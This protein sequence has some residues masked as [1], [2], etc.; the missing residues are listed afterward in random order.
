M[1]KKRILL[2]GF[3]LLLQPFC[4]RS[5]QFGSS[6]NLF[7]PSTA[8]KF[9]DIGYELANKPSVSP[10]E[11]AAKA[12]QALIFMTAVTR[13]DSHSHYVLADMIR[14]ASQIESPLLLG[15]PYSR[16]ALIRD[17]ND[18]NAKPAPPRDNSELIM[19]ALKAYVNR[20]ADLE[21]AEQAIQYLLSHKDTREQKEKLLAELLTAF[22]NKND[23]LE[24]ELASTLGLLTAEK[25][26][27]AKA[28]ILF[29]GAYQK[30]RYNRTAFTKLLEIEP[31]QIPAVM[32]LEHLRYMLGENPLDIQAALAFADYSQ[33]LQLFEIACD[34]YEY[35]ASLFEYLYPQ[36]TLPEYIYLGLAMS[37]YNTERNPLKAVQVAERLSREG[38][39]DLLLETIA[40]RA[41]VKTG[42][43]DK[44]KSL[45]NAAEKAALAQIQKT[46]ADRDFLTAQLA[47]FYCFAS[48]QAD[49]AI[50]WANKAYAQ[51]PNNSTAA[52]LLA[53]AFVM[54]DNLEWAKTFVES[55]NPNPILNL[56]KARIDLSQDK[57]ENAIATLKAIIDSSPASIEANEARDILKSIG[58]TYIPAI[59]PKLTEIAL[60]G[61]FGSNIVP[62]FRKPNEILRTQLNIRGDKFSYG[63][64]FNA[65]LVITNTSP[66]PLV[67]SDNGLFKG[68]IRIDTEVSGDIKRQINNLILKRI[69]PSAPI[70]RNASL[71]VPLRLMTGELRELLAKYP[72]AS[73]EISFTVYL[74]PIILADASIAN[75]LEDI[76]PLTSKVHRPAVELTAQF[77]RNRMNT[78]RRERQSYRTAELFSG[79]LIEEYEM[80]KSGPLYN[81]MYAEWMSEMLKSSIAYNLTSDSW[82]GRIH[83][84]TS[85]LPLPLDFELVE[86]VSS[87]LNHEHWPVRLMALYLL[88]QN[89][90]AGFKQ[91]LD[92]TAKFDSGDLVRDM[93]VA[94]GGTTPNN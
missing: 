78:I 3:I 93:A 36:Q 43:P 1:L 92:Y 58:S 64:D 38:V 2:I 73:L 62:I 82:D 9:Y 15:L 67:I 48:P 75:R 86:A 40:A 42:Q 28:Q 49:K 24:S 20:S 77:L 69:R 60:K 17:V 81:L 71:I 85:L 22:R 32:Y 11:Q 25:A 88:A 41:A 70:G 12:Q 18:P 27:F 29:F 13:L 51:E 31:N 5:Q 14:L 94:L 4:A 68:Y 87:N 30:N 54:N 7:S 66:E 44:A 61:T 26:D 76:Q 37:A 90:T 89:Q 56:V 63:S 34:A 8:L 91:V 53:Y 72:Q 45:L 74:D 50:D 47:W 39:N 84:M 33:Q 59:D 6:D 79:L 23:V 35:T 52:A 46:D 57:K 21:I 80:S 16:Q 55:Y 65:S 10:Q 19:Q 83:T